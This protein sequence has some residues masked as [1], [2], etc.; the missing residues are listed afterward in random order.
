MEAIAGDDAP[1]TDT[2]PLVVVA[3]GDDIP[4]HRR[5]LAV[6]DGILAAI[7]AGRLSPGDR[8][9][10][11]RELARICDVSRTTVRD[12]LL[13]LEL[14]GVVEVRPGSGCY[15]G[16]LHPARRRASSVVLDSVPR[17]LLEARLHVEPEVARIC[18]GNVS[19]E[20]IRRLR[21]LIDACEAEGERASADDLGTFLKMSQEFH[22][23]MALSCGNGVLADFTSQLVD[24]TAH[25]LWQVVN[26]MHVRDPEA[27]ASQIAE[28]RAILAAV[29]SGDGELASAQMRRHLASLESSIFGSGRRRDGISRQRRRSR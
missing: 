20:E 17:D 1:N 25:P 28:H 26:S 27:R 10:N 16:S 7:A 21:G 13:A 2:E 29:E 11:E 23:E 5:Y 8:L 14:F 24:V 6:A 9:P 15:V 3:E 4:A 22:S 18:A 19:P 12:A